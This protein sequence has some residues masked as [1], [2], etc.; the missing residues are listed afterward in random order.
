MWGKTIVGYGQYHYE[1]E[2][3][4]GGDWFLVG[5]SPR[6]QNLVKYIMTEFTNFDSLLS[7]LGKHKLGKSCLYIKKLSDVNIEVFKELIIVA[8]APLKKW[9]SLTEWF[10]FLCFEHP[11]QKY[12][13]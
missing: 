12:N 8:I 11:I 1:Y 5:F 4:M 10:S 13:C 2:S 6:K 3:G 9:I 7:K